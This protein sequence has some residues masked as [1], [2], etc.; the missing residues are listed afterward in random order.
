MQSREQITRRQRIKDTEQS[1]NISFNTVTDCALGKC[2]ICDCRNHHLL[3]AK[4]PLKTC[5]NAS[6][7]LIVSGITQGEARLEIM[8]NPNM[9]EGKI[10]ESFSC[11]CYVLFSCILFKAI[12][13]KQN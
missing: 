11:M 7:G 9:E 3:S 6:W 1:E 13:I 4:A 10:L 12:L 2:T 8:N 5:K